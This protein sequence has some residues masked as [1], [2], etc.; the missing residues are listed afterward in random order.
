[1]FSLLQSLSWRWRLP[2]LEPHQELQLHIVMVVEM[3]CTIYVK[4]EHYTNIDIAREC[5]SIV[6]EQANTMQRTSRTAG[7]RAAIFT[8]SIIA[9]VIVGGAAHSRDNSTM[10]SRVTKHSSRWS[11]EFI[12]H[13]AGDYC[14]TKTE[15]Q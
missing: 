1:M 15:L 13:V 11:E 7:A 5:R 4:M 10:E 3:T 9:R 12:L 6:L 2:F 8:Q 14:G